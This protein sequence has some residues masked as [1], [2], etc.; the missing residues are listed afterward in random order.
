MFRRRL[1]VNKPKIELKTKIVDN[2]D[3]GDNIDDGDNID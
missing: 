3:S 2:I 1:S